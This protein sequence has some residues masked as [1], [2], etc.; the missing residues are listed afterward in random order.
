MKRVIINCGGAIRR[1]KG[2]M[3]LMNFQLIQAKPQ[4]FLIRA[5]RDPP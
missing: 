4:E 5:A 1:M 3:V 2:D